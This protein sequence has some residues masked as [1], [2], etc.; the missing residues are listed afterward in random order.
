M[1]SP[2]LVAIATGGRAEKG[3]ISESRCDGVRAAD[4]RAARGD[5]TTEVSV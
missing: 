4:G 5:N 3:L 2:K 1:P